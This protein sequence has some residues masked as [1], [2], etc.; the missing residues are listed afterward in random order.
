MSPVHLSI[1]KL[2]LA[3]TEPSRE[4]PFA[5]PRRHGSLGE[6]PTA[7]AATHATITYALF[8]QAAIA[9]AT[10]YGLMNHDQFRVTFTFRV[11]DQLW[12]LTRT[13]TRLGSDQF[14][15]TNCALHRMGRDNTPLSTI[16]GSERVDETVHRLL[17]EES[18]ALVECETLTV[19]KDIAA[20]EAAINTTGPRQHEVLLADAKLRGEPGPARQ[21]PASSRTPPQLAQPC[22]APDRGSRRRTSETVGDD[23]SMTSPRWNRVAA[24]ASRARPVG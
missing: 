23:G 10:N 5:A 6:T 20:F 24:D 4:I 18:L 3:K 16:E 15:D 13:L 22:T 17:L 12:K 7:D 8:G 2:R 14:A 11:S 9:G 19:R 1:Q 21:R